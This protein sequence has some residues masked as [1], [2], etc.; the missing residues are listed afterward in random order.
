MQGKISGLIF[1]NCTDEKSCTWIDAFRKY[2]L[3]FALQ[4]KRSFQYKS[5]ASDS[6]LNAVGEIRMHGSAHDP[7]GL[8]AKPCKHKDFPD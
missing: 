7:H 1:L 2:I 6:S 8:C 5:S 3:R 4:L